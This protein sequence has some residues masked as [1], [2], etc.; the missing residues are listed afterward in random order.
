MFDFYILLVSDNLKQSILQHLYSTDPAEGPQVSA[1][2]LYVQILPAKEVNNDVIS[3]G[4]VV[5]AVR[6]RFHEGQA[7][8]AQAAQ[9]RQTRAPP[10]CVLL[11][12]KHTTL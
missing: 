7:C 1:L 9:D 10:H 8:Q 6:P 3:V 2:L 4:T 5:G 12:G 11:E